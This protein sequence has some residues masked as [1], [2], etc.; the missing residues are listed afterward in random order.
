[1]SLNDKNAITSAIFT[2]HKDGKRN[3]DIVKSLKDLSVSYRT[4]YKIVKRYRETS[5]TSDRPRSGRP[6]TARTPAR[7]KRVREKVRRDCTR[8]V[9]KLAKEEGTSRATMQRIIK[10]DLK[11][12]SF[13]RVKM[14]L[15]SKATKKKRLERA[16][17]LLKEVNADTHCL[18]LFTDEKIFTVQATQNSQNHRVLAKTKADVPLE[19]R[20]VF[21]R[22]NPAS[23]MVWAGVLSDGKKTPLIF[24]PKGVKVNKD[25]YLNLLKEDLLPWLESEYGDRLYVFSQDGAPAHTAK[26]VQDW[27]QENFP[28]FW[29]KNMWPPSSPDF[30]V[31]DYS[32]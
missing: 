31:M 27:C 12:S 21:R 10:N 14:Q 11:L 7:V 24:V 28:G 22:Q 23:V 17:I 5:K 13:K 26:M 25:V 19:K 2:L 16:L 9:R 1:M 32:I 29:H 3:G 30:N 18:I 15:L 8:S 20:A 6:R 4:V